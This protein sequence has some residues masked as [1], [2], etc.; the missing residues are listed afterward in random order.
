MGGSLPVAASMILPGP[1]AAARL[2]CKHITESSLEQEARII[3]EGSSSRTAYAF[4]RP[5][6]SERAG[7][8]PAP[9]SMGGVG[10]MVAARDE[11]VRRLFPARNP[12]AGDSEGS[13][14]VTGTV[15]GHFQLQE[16]IGR[17]GMGAVFRAM[18]LRLERVV[19][20]K[21]LSP[22]QSH[23]PGAVVRFQNEAR[24]A[25]R[26]DQDN[27][28]QVYFIGEDQGLQF[29][30]FE[31]ITGTNV[32]ELLARLGT[33]P[34]PEA[35]SYTLQI[36]EALRS[37]SAA[38][39][40]HRDIKP[41]NIIIEP[42]GRVTLV[43]LGLAR[44][45]GGSA[46]DELT[47]AGTT[48]GT[49]DYISPEQAVDPRRVDVRSDIYSLGCTLYHMVTGEPPYP[50][51]SMFQKVVDHHGA[52]AP[53]P[54]AKNPRISP[55]LSA[56][57]R[58]MMASDPDDRFPTPESL[59]RELQ[60][61]AR[62]LGVQPVYSAWEA[63]PRALVWL[64]A[65]RGWLAAAT[66]VVLLGLGINKLPAIPDI[67]IGYSAVREETPAP[68][69][70][71]IAA[72]PPAASAPQELTASSP[73][74]AATG[75]ERES[76]KGS[77]ATAP[78]GAATV[79][80]AAGA[81]P[82]P[83]NL[84]AGLGSVRQDL[85]GVFSRPGDVASPEAPVPVAQPATVPR[86]SVFWVVTDT[87]EK[88]YPTL[89][90]ACTAASDNATIEIRADGPLPEPQGPI[91]VDRK[92]LRIRPGTG[93]RPAIEFKDVSN[94]ASSSRWITIHAGSLDISD[95]E[96]TM[97]VPAT[98]AAD[99]WAMFSLER[100]QGLTL[101]GTT[102]TLQNDERNQPAV[103]VEIARESMFSPSMMVDT[104]A[105]TTTV[106][107][108]RESLLRGECDVIGARVDEALM[109]SFGSSAIAV[110]GGVF[111]V[112][113]MQGRSMMPAE[114]RS[115]A[116]Q[117]DHVTTVTDH[118]L[119]A[120]SSERSRP[121]L[122]SVSA[123]DSLF[124]V[125]RADRPVVAQTGEEEVDL[126]RSRLEW[127]GNGN[128]FE[129]AG[130]MWEIA[131]TP[132]SA[133]LRSIGFKDWTRT[134][135]A[136]NGEQLLATSPFEAAEPWAVPRFSRMPALAFLVRS[137]GGSILDRYGRPAGVDVTRLPKTPTR[138]APGSP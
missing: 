110:S 56:V 100:C 17:G 114:E 72:A 9:A 113:L 66:I 3:G 105:A 111:R 127:R 138:L 118:P 77:V 115:M 132:G 107:D 34:I 91:R 39:V 37:T 101:R 80:S 67:P 112:D 50:S 65:Y 137:Q 70:P 109:V 7:G 38:G 15:L 57:I 51:N 96:L 42:T 10:G 30:A 82:K 90:A 19:A 4:L 93:F 84:T 88:S 106:V 76:P 92:R 26:L 116:L 49:F 23:D 136:S 98:R 63:R 81:D 36:A 52:V 18:D 24:A 124:V 121:P 86:E 125:R 99:R 117:F 41:S 102:L 58:R 12:V 45:S 78:P 55:Q 68:A 35:V 122:I 46:R 43:D 53:D 83:S 134:V 40:V 129:T 22:E 29:I 130:A 104:T 87:K 6:P 47:V 73:P 60:P 2:I 21:V 97:K 27:I 44:Q 31:F 14:S 119:V 108:I 126:W 28:A 75:V 64:R 5:L 8:V 54:R 89:E 74:P 95:C 135:T 25:A 1:E 32:R 128:Y 62:S 13:L 85:T 20:L 123:D 103:L 61:V 79:G 11:I 16:R 33:L 131:S 133:P 69:A 48:L 59:I 94:P 71:L 120:V